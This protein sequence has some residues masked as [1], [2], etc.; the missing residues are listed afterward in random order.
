MG[1]ARLSFCAAGEGRG[2]GLHLDHLGLSRARR[3]EKGRRIL[4]TL[5]RCVAFS[6]LSALFGL[7]CSSDPSS[8]GPVTTA[9]GMAS[10]TGGMPSAGQ[11]PAGGG[12]A[13]AGS[14]SVV[15]IG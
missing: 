12:A 15:P 14:A 4:R 9:G 6:L 2:Q 11:A 1:K 13:T 10:Q 8:G 7:A 5:S 3:F